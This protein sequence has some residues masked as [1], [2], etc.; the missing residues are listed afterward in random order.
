M[1]LGHPSLHNAV[2]IS[3]SANHASVE[4]ALLEHGTPGEAKPLLGLCAASEVPED[5]TSCYP[6]YVL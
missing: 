1:Y 3:C 6:L 5:S 2:F 4:G